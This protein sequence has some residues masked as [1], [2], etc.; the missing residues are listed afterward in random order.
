MDIS[1]SHHPTP[2][3]ASPSLDRTVRVFAWQFVDISRV[4]SAPD[5]RLASNNNAE[6]NNLFVPAF[7]ILVHRAG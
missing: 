5:S 6:T 4:S 3:K 7:I 2:P 1:F